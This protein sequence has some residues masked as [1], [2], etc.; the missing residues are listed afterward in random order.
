MDLGHMAV[1]ERPR[2]KTLRG[3]PKKNMQ[4][5]LFIVGIRG[6]AVPFP[7]A[8]VEV[9]LDGSPESFFAV[10]TDRGV[11]K[12]RSCH[13]VPDAKLHDLDVLSPGSDKPSSKFA[14]KPSGL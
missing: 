13:P 2:E 14:G 8:G 3:A 11:D 12:I 10:D 9:D 4:P 7:I 6:V 1:R 5:H